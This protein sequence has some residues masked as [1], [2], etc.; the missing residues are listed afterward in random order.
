[1]MPETQGKPLPD[2]FEDLQKLKEAE[3]RE[4]DANGAVPGR[5]TEDTRRHASP[6]EDTRFVLTEEETTALD[7]S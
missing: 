6:G 2:T 1:M 5:G 7:P 4:T 3:T